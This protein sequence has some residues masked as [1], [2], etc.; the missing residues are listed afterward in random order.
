MIFCPAC[1][2]FFYCQSFSL[3]YLFK[4]LGYNDLRKI[5]V[6]EQIGECKVHIMQKGRGR[7]AGVAVSLSLLV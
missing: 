5:P 3:R 7:V 1:L 6:C 4:I 2:V